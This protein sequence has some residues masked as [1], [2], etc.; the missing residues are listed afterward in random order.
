MIAIQNEETIPVIHV[1]GRIDA[2][3]KSELELVLL[4]IAHKA[5]HLIINLSE[6]DYLSSA[7]IRTLL[8][9]EKILKS[10]GGG[11]F[12]CGL[13]A[14][15]YQIIEMAGMLQIFHVCRDIREANNEI[16]KLNDLT[17]GSLKWLSEGLAFEFLP[18]DNERKA[19]IFW[20]FRLIRVF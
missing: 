20:N 12:L 19:A 2:N 5:K 15:V 10:K 11:L 3:T 14:D 9:T 17:E 8:I 7:G 6:C 4:P 16:V 1:S 13:S 18:V